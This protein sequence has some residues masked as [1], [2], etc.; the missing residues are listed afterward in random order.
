MKHRFLGL[1]GKLRRKFNTADRLTAFL[2]ACLVVVSLIT[3]LPAQA[4]STDVD[5]NLGGVD[6][7]ISRFSEIMA[8]SFNSVMSQAL[9]INGM[10]HKYVTKVMGGS[11]YTDGLVLATVG[12]VLGYAGGDE[13]AADVGNVWTKGMDMASRVMTLETVQNFYSENGNENLSE[14]AKSPVVEY[15]LW[16]NVLNQLGVDEFRDAQG[17]ADGLRSIIG[18]AAYVFFILAY[19][20]SNIMNKV[21][22]LMKHF[23]VFAGIWSLFGSAFNT[24]ASAGSAGGNVFFG[25]WLNTPLFQN[26][27]A[28]VLTALKG[29][30]WVIFGL[31]AIFIV[32]S[33]TVW[34]SKAYGHDASIQDR[35]R[36]LAYRIIIACIGIPLIGMAYTEMLNVVGKWS[37]ANNYKIAQY[38]LQEFMDF[39][40]WTTRSPSS[41]FAMSDASDF[42]TIDVTYN[43]K[44]QSYVILDANGNSV[45]SNRLVYQINYDLHKDDVDDD[46]NPIALLDPGSDNL[47]FI[48]SLFG[49]DG[50]ATGTYSDLLQPVV[51]E[52]TDAADADADPNAMDSEAA[53]NLCRNLLLNYARS[54]TV[55]P[56][57]LNS[58]Y[59]LDIVYL[60]SLL[61]EPTDDKQDAQITDHKVVEQLFGEDS[62]NQRIWSYIKMDRPWIYPHDNVDRVIQ[63]GENTDFPV[64]I[65]IKGNAFVSSL[66]GM[67]GV[68]INAQGSGTI[69]F[70]T[71]VGRNNYA[72]LKTANQSISP[73]GAGASST[74]D[75]GGYKY[76]YQFQTGNGGMSPLA[77]YNYMHTRFDN[78]SIAVYSP[79]NTTNAGV[80]MMHYAVTT[81][82]S[83]IPELV[84]LLF[85]VSMLFSVGILGWVFG[86]SL[87][88]NTIVQ[89]IKALPIMLKMM[90]GSVQGFVEGL[91]IV[92]SVI[93]ELLVTITLYTWSLDIIDFVIKLLREVVKGILSI[94]TT[95]IVDSES[96]AILSGLISAFAIVWATFQLIKWR[97]AITISINSIVTHVLNQVF[98]TSAKMPT[99]ASSGMMKAA[100]ALAAGAM[101]AGEMADQG[102]LD[103]V[104]N[105]FTD[106]DL[107]TSLHDKIKE[108]DYEGALQ[109][110]QDYASGNYEGT[111]GRSETSEAE[112]ALRD[113]DA[114]VGGAFSDV[115]QSLTN[116]QKEAEESLNKEIEEASAK[117]QDALENGT[118]EEQQQA[119]DELEGK[120]AQRRDQRAAW[121]AE[122]GQKA[123]EAGVADYGDYLRAQEA[124]ANGYA[125]I[126]GADIPEEATMD[127]EPAELTADAQAIYTAAHDGNGEFLRSMG[128]KV[129]GNGMF[130]DDQAALDQMVLDGATEEQLAAE[131]A[132]RQKANF[133]DNAEEVIDKLNE[134]NG[135][136]SSETYGDNNPTGDQEARTM[137]V[138]K[139]NGEDG[140]QLGV[141]DNSDGSQV[142][143]D[144]KD[145]GSTSVVKN[146]SFLPEA[147]N[148]QLDAAAMQAYNAVAQNNQEGMVAAAGNYNE[149]G[150][151]AQ[152]AQVVAQ[153]VAN[154][155]T[156]AEVAAAC[157][158]FAQDNFGDNYA[159]VVQG[160]NQAA[161]R[162]GQS[163]QFS[164]MGSDGVVR[165]MDLK[166]D[167]DKGGNVS[168]NAGG[169]TVTVKDEGGQS[170]FTSQATGLGGWGGIG[171]ASETIVTADYGSGSGPAGGTYAELRLGADAMSVNSG[172]QMVK[173]G[174]VT[175]GGL[176]GLSSTELAAT[177]AAQQA[178]LVSGQD[179]SHVRIG[180]LSGGTLGTHVGAVNSLLAR[181]PEGQQLDGSQGAGWN[182]AS[183]A[184]DLT[185]MSKTYE[186]FQRL[187]N[188]GDGDGDGD[189]GGNVTGDRGVW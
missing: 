88:M 179:V 52:G 73:V 104:V 33:M 184:G 56:D 134:A 105:D 71:L 171:K 63:I 48:D 101:V 72:A 12:N 138:Q 18:Y 147:P 189:G 95:G 120:L 168:Y 125:P 16:G 19:S 51:V 60:S 82:Y 146:G 22:G 81:P 181:G 55:L 116:D 15:I 85:T 39:E 140:A 135:R 112:Q 149:W 42:S 24:I 35:W 136:G 157:N 118:E 64:K 92:I 173:M 166:M 76:E 4:S 31:M 178:Q 89:M 61:Y 156:A 106:S 62:A 78:G 14:A 175:G 114:R 75:G 97:R 121:K 119:L 32:A 44:T 123:R 155:A 7:S 58:E 1:M 20:A 90:L 77:L 133:G 165:T 107:G 129:D 47:V 109:D 96:S 86:I 108:G 145:D 27:I 177:I 172:G 21:V 38:V 29:L 164:A 79:D 87:L 159:Q 30:R 70:N 80:G 163:A 98:G 115:Q 59:V 143:V 131:I 66:T 40:G 45:D 8:Q 185:M 139:V 154:G 17:A 160:L 167:V 142:L 126:E 150:G 182:A 152:Q 188:G 23:N 84:Q 41:A 5:S 122:N 153:M 3:V 183:I 68:T 57:S 67:H 26:R 103:D 187:M 127:G 10:S 43:S 93:A 13:N 113:A 83:G 69:M 36:K 102:V 46:N 94:F 144:V 11:S 132:K 100:G 37:Q 99:G 128:G 137:T 124:G 28:P 141:T 176:E 162:V 53:Y 174:T 9:P 158:N 25:E 148:T 186:Q 2:A 91:L 54:N 117:Y 34:K 74:A 6:S 170:T 110:I 49:R 50:N 130:E 169:Q 151:T 161:G 111:R 180:D 65:T